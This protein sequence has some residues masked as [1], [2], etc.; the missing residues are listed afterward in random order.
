MT[1]YQGGKQRY[2][3]EIHDVISEYESVIF[4]GRKLNLLS[5]FFGMGSVE[6]KFVRE[7]ERLVRASDLNEDVISM[8]NALKGGEW[9]PKMEISEEEY[10]SIKNG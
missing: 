4:K 1:R 7:E 8:W 3:N 5:P 9:L 10:N 6:L 2:A